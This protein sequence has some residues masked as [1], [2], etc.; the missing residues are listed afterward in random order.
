MIG[1]L[2]IKT[3]CRNGITCL[4]STY[5]TPPFKLMNITE[6]KQSEQLHLMMMNSSPGILD[7]DLYNIKIEVGENSSLQ[8][9]SQS[10]QRLF[11]MKTGAEQRME[12]HLGKRSSF[13]YLPH[14]TVPHKN[15][16]FTVRNEIWLDDSSSLV[17]GEILTCGRKLSEAPAL[18][19]GEVFRLSKYQNN[20]D[21]FINGKLTIRENLLVQPAV[22]DPG[23]IGQ[24]EGFTHQASLICFHETAFVN[25]QADAVHDYLLNQE[26][27]LFGVTTT[28]GNGLL[29]RILGYGAEQLHQQLQA[30][31]ILIRQKRKIE[32]SQPAYAN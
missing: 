18:E 25:D 8:L 16:I 27:I 10:Y 12:V 9:H 20:T 5:F 7:G 29:V 11:N 28:A 23:K 1:Q 6:N 24:L 4:G 2:H 30:I 26:R 31:A 19:S 17:W 32:S 14:P 15:S 22:T 21:V 3:F 13:I